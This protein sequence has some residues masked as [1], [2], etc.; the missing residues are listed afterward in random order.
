MHISI[1]SAQTISSV[2]RHQFQSVAHILL[3]LLTDDSEHTSASWWHYD[4]PVRRIR[5]RGFPQFL[6][7]RAN[8]AVDQL[9]HMRM[10]QRV[11]KHTLGLGL[12]RQQYAVRASCIVVSPGHGTIDMHACVHI[13]IVCTNK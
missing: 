13:N 6:W 4:R 7:D 2:S 1:V 8:G 12:G 11:A 3:Y 5:G 9:S 10:D